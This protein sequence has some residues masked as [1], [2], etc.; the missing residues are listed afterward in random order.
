MPYIEDTTHISITKLEA[1]IIFDRMVLEPHDEFSLSVRNLLRVTLRDEPDDR[2]SRSASLT[3]SKRQCY[4]ILN[5]IRDSFNNEISRSLADKLM[6]ALL[7]LETKASV[8]E[9]LRGTPI[10]DNPGVDLSYDES[11]QR[12]ERT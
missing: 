6:D 5:T 11:R 9:F 12:E 2:H 7:Y 10:L 3:V 1:R 4:R 8:A